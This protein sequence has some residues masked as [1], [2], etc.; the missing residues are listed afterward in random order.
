[1]ST[2]TARKFEGAAEGA[3]VR[4][5][6]VREIRSP[7]QASADTRG[8]VGLAVLRAV[9]GVVFVAHG[10]QKLF[11]FGIPG[12]VGA[13][14]GMGVPMAWAA[15]PAV[16]FVELIG[17]LLLVAGFLT[18]YVT[19]ALVGVM[20]GA[21]LLVHLPAGFFLPNGFEF[22]LTL[23]AIAGAFFLTGPGRYSVDGLLSER[24]TGR[25]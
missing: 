13:F 1:M 5:A 21:L 8:D 9:A 18:R 7:N 3:S 19:V 11:V 22:V 25:V 14:E 10:A 15:G 20:L 24:R 12:V 16:A 4:E 17:G 6:S 2:N 23:G